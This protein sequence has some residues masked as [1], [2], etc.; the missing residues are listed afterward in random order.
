[1]STPVNPSAS[2]QS[3]MNW[4]GF[5]LS[6]APLALQ[7]VVA[8]QQIF[9]KGNGKKKSAAVQKVVQA[10]VPGV[11]A[12][13]VQPVID[14]SVAAASMRFMSDVIVL[15]VFGSNRDDSAT[16]IEP[17]TSTR[18]TVVP[19][20]GAMPSMVARSAASIAGSNCGTMRAAAT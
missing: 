18:T 9:G 19:S 7:L 20:S 4:T 5:A 14:A 3:A 11:D 12:A 17:E 8:M 1:M 6:V 13:A 10:A 2:L 16:S 15:R